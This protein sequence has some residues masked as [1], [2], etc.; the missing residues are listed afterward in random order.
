VNILGL[1]EQKQVKLLLSVLPRSEIFWNMPT[2]VTLTDGIL[3]SRAAKFFEFANKRKL[4]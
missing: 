1:W 2:K 3:F 4:K